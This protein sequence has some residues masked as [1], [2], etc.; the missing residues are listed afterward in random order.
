MAKNSRLMVVLGLLGLLTTSCA[1]PTTPPASPAPTAVPTQ[2]AAATLPPAAT[3]APTATTAPKQAVVVKMAIVDPCGE[4]N[5]LDP[6]NQ[7][8]GECQV[9]INQVYN[10]L[11]DMDSNFQVRPE[12]AESFESNKD[13]T[14]WTFHLRKGVKFH[15]GH[16]LSSKDVVWT[17]KRLID[18]A[19]SSEAAPS[20]A[21]L[22]S[23]GIVALDDYTVKFVLDK[24][25]PDLPVLVTIKNTWIVPDGATEQTLRL[26]GVGTGPFIPVKFEPVQQPH[27]FVKNPNYWEA[28][29]PKADRME[30]YLIPEATTRNAAIQSGQVDIVQNVDFSTLPALQKDTNI[31]ILSTG[32]STSLVFAM[33]V[34]TPPYNDLRVRQALKKVVD[35]QAMVATALLGYGTIGDD[36]PIPPV[37][38]YAWRAEVPARDVEGAKKLLAQAGYT[39]DKPLKLD[40]YT[41]EVLP[42]ALAMAQLFREQAAQAGIKVN[43][44]VSPPAE[45]W[46]TVWLKQPFVVSG[47]VQR[48]PAEALAIAYRSNSKYP[49]THWSRPD[50]DKI[51][52]DANT[53][54]DSQKR[55]ELY[56]KAE[57]M[58]TEEGGAIIPMFFYTTAAIRTNCTGY[59]PHVQSSRVDTRYVTCTQ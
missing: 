22:K 58:L 15:D 6:I 32:P 40:L 47:W 11:L 3:T 13:A 37:S 17:F 52:D 36:N 46:D 4:K 16:E 26:N 30:F 38:P 44:I 7:P 27:V 2:V 24:P 20:L 1:A 55:L 42:G 34:D 12:L 28:G 5:S 35:R 41:S 57:Q 50:F 59:T 43:V 23:S 10:R 8:D 54:V 18:P 25:V 31:K 19:S 33:M 53:T 48:H 14:E 51:L 45:Y 49:E 56:K 9:M 29:L 21:F 39:A